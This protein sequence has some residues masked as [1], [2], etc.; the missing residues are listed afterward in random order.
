MTDEE[1]ELEIDEDDDEGDKRAELAFNFA[2]GLAQTFGDS[3]E[4][5]TSTKQDNGHNIM[6]QGLIFD[7]NSDKT[8]PFV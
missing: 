3:N 4:E 1:I 2:S 6:F 8:Q 7:E 5:L